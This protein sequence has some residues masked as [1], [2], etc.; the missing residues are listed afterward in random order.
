MC[1][2]EGVSLPV[3]AREGEKGGRREGGELAVAVRG[4]QQFGEEVKEMLQV[5]GGG[6][7]R[8][9][10]GVGVLV[11]GEEMLVERKGS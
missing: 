11:G 5:G 8:V 4:L 7:V 9:G 6:E 10:L 3:A 1:K 2:Q